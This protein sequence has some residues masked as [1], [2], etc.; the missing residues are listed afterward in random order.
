M[1]HV[2]EKLDLF[3]CIKHSVSKNMSILLDVVYYCFHL[4]EE[5]FIAHMVNTFIEHTVIF[6]RIPCI[7]SAKTKILFLS[8]YSHAI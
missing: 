2:L 4:I 7:R 3:T 1:C 8:S 6:S 5:Y